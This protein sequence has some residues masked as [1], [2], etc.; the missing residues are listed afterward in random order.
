MIKNIQNE[1]ISSSYKWTILAIVSIGVFMSTL[2]G[3]IVNVALPTISEYFN[4]DIT[5]IE[6]VLTAYFLTITCLLLSIGRLSDMIGRKIIFFIGFAVFT[7]GSGLCAMSGSETQLIIFRII[8]GIGAAMIMAISP[9]IITNAFPESELGKAFGLIGAVIGLGSMTGPVLGGFLTEAFGW[10]SIFYINLPI[11]VLGLLCIAYRMHE[12]RNTRND[13]QFD[14][15]GAGALFLSLFSLLIALNTGQYLGWGSLLILFMLS[16]FIIFFTVFIMIEKRARHPIIELHLFSNKNFAAANICL[17]ITFIAMFSVIF[18]MP[19][20]LENVSN[21]PITKIGMALF[22]MPLFMSLTAPVSGWLSDRTNSFV[23]SRMGM[24]IIFIA[25]LLISMVDESSDFL[26]IALRLGLLGLGIGIFQ[27]PNNSIIMSSVP[28]NRLGVASG[29]MATMRSM[30][31]ILGVAI[32]G[33]VFSYRFAQYS[34]DAYR[35]AFQDTYSAIAIICIIGIIFSFILE[36][37]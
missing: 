9:A 35:Y 27:S 7:L 23:Y 22:S 36:R 21:Y 37:E 29:T 26:G 12:D 8:Q 15:K 25:I 6:W 24:V 10:R 5:T 4:T 32:A 20:F 30:G 16:S 33:A 31:M 11:G 1:N 17:L 19:F 13:Q 14:I 2:D 18:I 28:K 3:S 34:S